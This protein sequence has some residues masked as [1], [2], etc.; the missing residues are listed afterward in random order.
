MAAGDQSFGSLIRCDDAGGCGDL[1]VWE[2]RVN[3]GPSSIAAR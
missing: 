3:A 2:Q 1:T